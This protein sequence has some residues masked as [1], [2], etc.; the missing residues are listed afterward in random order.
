MSNRLVTNSDPETSVASLSSTP[1]KPLDVLID[2]GATNHVTSLCHLFVSFTPT[3]TQLRVASEEQLPIV[4]VGT[5]I[6]PTSAGPLH[7]SRVLFCP[8][9]WGTVLSVGFFDRWDGSISFSQG[10]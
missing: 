1:D 3:D 9:V 5:V 2:S 7:I 10:F 4:G 8:N 6:L